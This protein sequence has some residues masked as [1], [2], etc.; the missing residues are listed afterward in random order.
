MC[1]TAFATVLPFAQQV[2]CPFEYDGCCFD[3][4]ALRQHYGYIAQFGYT[5]LDL[6]GF[7][8]LMGWASFFIY[9]LLFF[10]NKDIVL[11]FIVHNGIFG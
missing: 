1:V 4:D 3:I 2:I 8:M 11:S 10:L 9:M 5:G 7:K 6:Y